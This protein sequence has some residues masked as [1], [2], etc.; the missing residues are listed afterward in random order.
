MPP[1]RSLRRTG[2]WVR[3]HSRSGYGRQDSRSG[4]GLQQTHLKGWADGLT[5]KIT[6]EGSE[7]YGKYCVKEDE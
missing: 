6:N 4:R 5:S 3:R 1:R 7:R 2:S